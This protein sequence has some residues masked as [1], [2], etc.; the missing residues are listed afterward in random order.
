VHRLAEPS[1]R[2]RPFEQYRTT[3]LEIGHLRCSV[4]DRL[5]E[6]RYTGTARQDVGASLDPALRAL[7]PRAGS[8][9]VSGL[10]GRGGMTLW[11]PQRSVAGVVHH[12]RT[13]EP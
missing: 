4:L 12:R 10:T 1:A 7:C 3:P 2:R 5:L 8:P 9:I 11:A 6:P 13:V